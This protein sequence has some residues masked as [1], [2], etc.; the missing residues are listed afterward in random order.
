MGRYE[1]EAGRARAAVALPALA[2]TA[3]LS[4]GCEGPLITPDAYETEPPPAPLSGEEIQTMLIGNSVVSEAPRG[5]YVIFFPDAGQVLGR[6]SRHYHD[7]GQWRV[8]EG[9]ICARW[10]NWWGNT[11]RCWQVLRTGSG[12][13]W[14]DPYGQEENENA[15]IVA[16]NPAGLE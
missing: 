16:G 14:L 7:R 5:P 3:V 15:R 9:R 13:S 4:A 1:T 6:H 2:V 12:V 11:E 8:A 10:D